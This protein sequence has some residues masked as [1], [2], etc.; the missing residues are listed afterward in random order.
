MYKTYKLITINLYFFKFNVK[1]KK[2]CRNN[3]E[4]HVEW[5]LYLCLM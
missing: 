1:T 5:V 4:K 2:N 3:K